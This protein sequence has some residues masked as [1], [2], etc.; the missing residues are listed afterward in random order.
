MGIQAHHER[1]SS[2][3][4]NHDYD[5][6]SGAPYFT[7]FGE[8]AG[9][10]GKGYYSYDFGGWHLISLNSELFFGPGADQSEATA[11][12]NG[13]D[14]ISPIIECSARSPIFTSRF[15]TSAVGS[16]TSAGERYWLK[17]LYD[18]RAD[19]DLNGHEHHYERF[20]PQ[21]PSG[22]ADAANGIEEIITGTGGPSC[23]E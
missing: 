12:R 5:S 2:L 9:R 13:C 23:A 15:F 10:R 1:H 20:L 22:V 8:R 16:P 11:Q 21:T 7:Y 3:S 19:L 17:I 6:G 14:R 4:G 18:G